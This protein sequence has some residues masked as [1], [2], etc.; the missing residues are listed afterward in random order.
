MEPSAIR[1]KV[2]ELARVKGKEALSYKSDQPARSLSEMHTCRR[3]IYFARC[4]S[5]PQKQDVGRA[6]ARQF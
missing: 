2:S 6:L 1:L 5:K 3:E 4:L